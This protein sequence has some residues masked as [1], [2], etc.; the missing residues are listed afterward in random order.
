MEEYQITLSNKDLQYSRLD[1]AFSHFLAQRTPFITKQKADFE[2]LCKRLSLNLAQG[3]NC[4]HINTNEQSLVLAS[5]LASESNLTP[6]ILEQNR[7]YLYRYWFYENRLSQQ[8]NDL[9]TRSYPYKNLGSILDR[10]FIELIDETNWQ[11]EAAE[12][13]ITK[14]LSIIAGGP[15][16]GKTSTV[17]KILAILQELTAEEDIPLHIALTAPTGKAAIRLQQSINIHKNLLPCSEAIKQQIPNTVSTLHHLLGSKY[18]SPYFKH[19]SNYPLTYDLI[20][21]DEASMVDL[22]LMSKLVDALKPTAR[23]ILLGDKN[24]LAS[25]ESGA[26]LADLTAALPE[27]TVE[28]IK[29]YRFQGKI[30][31]L[32]NAVN[33]QAKDEAWQMLEEKHQQACLLE[34]SLDV[35]AA[36]KYTDY[37][38]QIEKNSDFN[39]IFAAFNQFQIVCSNR[40][41]TFGV[42]KVNRLVEEK[43]NQ[44]NKIQLSGR[45]YIGRPVIMTENNTGMSL[46]NGDIGICLYDKKSGKLSVFFQCPDGEIKKISPTRMPAHETAF[47]ITIHKSQGSE[48][49]ECLCILPDKINPVLSK[50][51][52][53]TAITRAKKKLRILSSRSIF[54][55]AL[56]QK[57][58]RSGGLYEKITK[59]APVPC[60]TTF[61]D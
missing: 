4:I 44:Q 34:E 53:Y 60:V 40:Q 15:G 26:V 9:L 48:F 39:V 19:D 50:E 14:G 10:Y 6:L 23:L 45:W 24:Q 30:K 47:A 42:I 3:H 57:V 2:A 52:I 37:L 11:K 18:L 31:T 59:T 13:A 7:L 8:I 20:I 41:G 28:L 16:T 55:H 1:T 61:K 29:S 58:D 17:V 38:Q 56:E 49:D 27:Q 5:G 35:Y 21:V 33:N 54:Y 46:Y 51:L 36:E 12:M 25:V 22:A 32:A 43:L